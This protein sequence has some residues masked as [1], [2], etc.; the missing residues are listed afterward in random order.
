MAFHEAFTSF[1][2]APVLAI[3]LVRRGRGPGI[4]NGEAGLLAPLAL[5]GGQEEL[6][7]RLGHRLDN[8]SNGLGEEGVQRK[9][10]QEG[11]KGQ[12]LVRSASLRLLQRGLGIYLVATVPGSRVELNK[13]QVEPSK[14]GATERVDHSVEP[15]YEVAGSGDEDHAG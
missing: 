10:L 12:H 9:G 13:A 7:E 1:L 2:A 6:R 4:G 15:E 5:P 3:V 11:A 8:R 14:V